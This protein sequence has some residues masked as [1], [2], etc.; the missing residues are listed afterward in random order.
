MP[1]PST[2]RHLVSAI[3]ILTASAGLAGCLDS[4][5]ADPTVTGTTVA[6]ELADHTFE[7]SGG[8][9]PASTE[10][11]VSIDADRDALTVAVTGAVT[12]STIPADARLE[13]LG[14]DA[15]SDVLQLRIVAFSPTPTGDGT[16]TSMSSYTRVE[17]RFT[18]QFEGALP[19][20][21]EV[22]HGDDS[23]PELVDT[24]GEN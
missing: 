24:T 10:E 3:G 5:R 20:R 15:E 6:T 7:T 21:V 18:G 17:Y 1:N 13:E 12:N 14:Y 23:E 2:R 4:S 8:D 9:D 22:Y 11:D 19:G 16:P